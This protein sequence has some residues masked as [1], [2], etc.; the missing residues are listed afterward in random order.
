MPAATRN[1]QILQ[2][3]DTVR[4]EPGPVLKRAEATKELLSNDVTAD[5]YVGPRKATQD[6]IADPN[7]LTIGDQV[8]RVD[9]EGKPIQLGEEIAYLDW[10]GH[11]NGEEG[12]TGYYVY[13]YEPMTP[14]ERKE[15]GLTDDHLA[16]LPA[17]LRE[18]ATMIWHEIACE[19]DEAAAI[20][21]ATD[22]LVAKGA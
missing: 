20:T 5:H 9:A 4:I 11:H 15:R 14:A 21:R 7:V 2:I 16:S 13:A 18:E 12:S 22:Y 8:F 10:L 6:E 3:G 19:A 17:D 1:G